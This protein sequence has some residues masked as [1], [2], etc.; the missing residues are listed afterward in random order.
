MWQELWHEYTHTVIDPAHILTELTYG[1]VEFAIG[2]LVGRRLLRH[3]DQ[4]VHGGTACD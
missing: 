3:H 4:R 1:L 2:F